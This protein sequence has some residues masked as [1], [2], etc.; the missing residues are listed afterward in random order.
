[1]KL[2][3]LPGLYEGDRLMWQLHRASKMWK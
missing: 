3:I 1:M 2:N